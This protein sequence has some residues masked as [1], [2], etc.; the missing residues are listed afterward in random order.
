MLANPIGLIVV[1]IGLLIGGLF[2]LVDNFDVVT[3]AFMSAMDFM[4]SGIMG[5]LN[6]LLNP[7][8]AIRNGISALG[9]FI[10]GNGGEA[11]AA[12]VAPNQSTLAAQEVNFNGQL[13]IAGAPEGSTVES[14]T[15]GAPPIQLNLA[16]AN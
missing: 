1:A 3:K 2:L 13:N 16:G 7:I 6:V 10:S 14:S 11:S 12:S 5:I 8:A 15:S 4:A 9:S